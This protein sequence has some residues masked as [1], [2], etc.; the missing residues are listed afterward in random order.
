MPPELRRADIERYDSGQFQLVCQRI[1]TGIILS[2]G[3]YLWA[4]QLDRYRRTFS[5]SL[6]FNLIS[7][8]W[9]YLGIGFSFAMIN[10]AA[11]GISPENY[12]TS[13]AHPSLIAMMVYSYASVTI[14]DGGGISAA[15]D[16]AFAIKLCTSF[17][18]GF[19][20][21]ALILNIFMTFRRERDDKEMEELVLDL[22]STARSQNSRF[23]E[24]FAIDVE[25]ARRRIEA[26]AFGMAGLVTM[27]TAL[28]P[29]EFFEYGDAPRGGAGSSKQPG[30]I[31]ECQL[32][33]RHAGYVRPRN[34]SSTLNR[35]GLGHQISRARHL[36]LP[37][38]RTHVIPESGERLV[39]TRAASSRS[40]TAHCAAASCSCAARIVEIACPTACAGV[41]SGSE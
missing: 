12:K 15:G 24:E 30:D 2:R 22:K 19:L 34:D 16:L 10:L 9:L 5:P 4:Y 33:L 37:S 35:A 36:A 31:P 38:Q 1:S 6:V 8:V 18:G 20:I 29:D 41:T 21:L 23:R 3:L 11:Y 28:I 39:Y 14:Q 26:L 32:S 7:F 40:C 25:E 27:I 17:I 13:V